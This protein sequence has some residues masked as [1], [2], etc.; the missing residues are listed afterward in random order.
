MPYA[1]RAR[2]PRADHPGGRSVAERHRNRG[3][4]LAT[5]LHFEEVRPGR[6]LRVLTQECA[7]LAFGHPAPD[8]E[9]HPVVE[10]IGAA[11]QLHRTVPADR[12][13]LALCRASN[14]KVIGIAS[15]TARLR[16]PCEASFGISVGQRGQSHC[17]TPPFTE[18]I[19]TPRVSGHAADHLCDVSHTNR[20]VVVQLTAF[21]LLIRARRMQ[22]T[23]RSRHART[24][25]NT[26]P[27]K[28]TTDRHATL[29][30]RDQPFGSH[31]HVSLTSCGRPLSSLDSR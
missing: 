21:N 1:K 10:C 22:V 5:P 4:S 25:T 15:A 23:V 11:L 18:P 28:P 31:G 12:C 7:A 20:F 3:E 8:S 30:V 9:L 26:P 14:K 16:D 24:E 17:G 2:G 27:C 29:P 13:S 6:D 19:G